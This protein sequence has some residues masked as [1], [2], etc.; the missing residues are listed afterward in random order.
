MKRTL[1]V[2]AYLLLPRMMIFSM[3]LRG[4]AICAILGAACAA[5]LARGGEEKLPSLR[6]AKKT[7]LS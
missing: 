3:V 1:L 5:A 2:L 6:L 7:H 4:C